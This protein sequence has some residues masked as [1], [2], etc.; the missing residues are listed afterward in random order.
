[1]SKIPKMLLVPSQETLFARERQYL[2]EKVKILHTKS[3][4]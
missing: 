2:P 1:M 4:L 3:M